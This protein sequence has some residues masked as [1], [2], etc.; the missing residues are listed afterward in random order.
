MITM[1]MMMMMTRSCQD[2]ALISQAREKKQLKKR[3]PIGAQI[4]QHTIVS[5][6]EKQKYPER[7]VQKVLATMIRRGEL[8]HR[9]Q[10]KMLYRI[11]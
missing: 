7:Q 10:R 4:S 8:Q 6:F 1:K 2:D 11:K 9:M 3:F 5:D